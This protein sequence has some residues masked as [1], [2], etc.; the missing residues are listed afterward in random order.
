MRLSEVFKDL[1][2]FVRQ[3]RGRISSEGLL[4]FTNTTYDVGTVLD[5]DIRLADGLTLV[6]GRAGVIHVREGSPEPD[7]ASTVVLQWIDLDDD[8]A[9]MLDRI[10]SREEAEGVPPFRLASVLP[11][12]AG[13]IRGQRPWPPPEHP[14]D[15]DDPELDDDAEAPPRS[16]APPQPES[17][18]ELGELVT[19][20]L[21]RS[22]SPPPRG[23]SRTASSGRRA[24]SPK[25]SSVGHL[26]RWVVG[27]G[28]VAVIVATVALMWL[29]EKVEDPGEPFLTTGVVPTHAPATTAT[30]SA[31]AAGATGPDDGAAPTPAEGSDAVPTVGTAEAQAPTAPPTA[32]P[33]V[34]PSPTAAPQPAPAA[35]LPIGM[36]PAAATELTIVED[37]AGTLVTIT[38]DGELA[39]DRIRHGRLDSPPGPRELVRLVGLSSSELEPRTEVAG[40][41]LTAVRTWLHDE[42]RPP[43]L[44]IVLDLADSTVHAAEPEIDG[45]TVSVRLTR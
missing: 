29:P 30:E 8:S 32:E 26:V 38:L 22:T 13:P 28:A 35:R 41:L 25:V 14:T 6:M 33:T 4:L 37:D 19:T 44:Y 18:E 3:H 24:T 40:P 11:P 31:A 39:P 9:A 17:A 15:E 7:R 21:G 10:E 42:L 27:L 2:E 16:P 34:P 5:I 23:S 36:P 1:G 20:A 45:R 43:E 12:P